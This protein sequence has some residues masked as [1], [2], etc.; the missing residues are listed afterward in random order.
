MDPVQ[1]EN[2][3]R[4]LPCAVCNLRVKLLKPTGFV[5]EQPV[6]IK[7]GW[8]CSICD[9]MPEPVPDV[10]NRTVKKML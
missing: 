9:L 2:L 3:L 7:Y 4:W 1:D 5:G 6:Y 10:D 8:I